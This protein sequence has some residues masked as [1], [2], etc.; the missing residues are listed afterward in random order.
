MLL[1]LALIAGAA[2]EAAAA[3]DAPIVVM[4]RKLKEWR[5]TVQSKDR[6][7][8]CRTV[9]PTGDKQIDAIG[10][11]AMLEC[12]PRYRARI[13]AGADRELPVAQRKQMNDAVNREMVA[14][15]DSEHQR[16]VAA[17]ADARVMAQQ[18]R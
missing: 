13:I 11:A 3:E 7:L 1:A 10:C 16:R 15:L 8:R 12:V 5:G 6:K 9:A 17:L 14:C 18:E 2:Q 4:S